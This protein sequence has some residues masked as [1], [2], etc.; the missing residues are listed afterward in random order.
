[1]NSLPYIDPD[2]ELGL[3]LCIA[4]I[5]LDKLSETKRGNPILS[6]DRAQ[7]Y[8][9]LAMRPKILNDVL[10]FLDKKKVPLRENEYFNVNAISKN[11]DFFYDRKLIKKL[12]G[13]IGSLGLLKITYLE[14]DGF[15]LSLTDHG[16][17]HVEK[18]T[19][20]YFMDVKRYSE[21]MMALQSVSINSLAG[22][23]NKFYGEA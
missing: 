16:K 20:S 7:I 14:K 4:L 12:I 5:V 6:I 10:I 2:R 15:V 23:L 3:N 13:L 17:A 21:Y 1:M 11:S 9:H 22:T 8:M 19:Q 18:L